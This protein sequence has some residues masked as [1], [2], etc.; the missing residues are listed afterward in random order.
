ML[1]GSVLCAEV[2]SFQEGTGEFTRCIFVIQ[3]PC[4]LRPM[5]KQ[6]TCRHGAATGLPD[7]Y[8]AFE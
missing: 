8:A 1:R 2:L 6:G 4:I 3:Q 7:A 5:A